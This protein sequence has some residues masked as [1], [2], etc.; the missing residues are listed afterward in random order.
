[1]HVSKKSFKGLRRYG[2]DTKKLMDGNRWRA[3]HNMICPTKQ[4]SMV[5]LPYITGCQPS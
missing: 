5:M 3:G 1:M 4:H 2:A